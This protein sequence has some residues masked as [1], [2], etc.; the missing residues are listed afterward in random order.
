[1]GS[2]WLFEYQSRDHH[3]ASCVRRPSLGRF[4]TGAALM[5]GLVMAGC[6]ADAPA[7]APLPPGRSVNTLKINGEERSYILR[8]PPKYD[9]KTKVPLVI[10]MNGA[11]DSAKYAEEAYHFAEKGDASN[12]ALVLPEALGEGHAWNG[13]GNG[14][15]EKADVAFL[16]NLLESLPKQYAIDTHHMYVSGHS[17]GAIMAY[18]IAA[19]RPDLVAAVGVVA[20]AVDKDFPTPKSPVPVI[21]FHGRQ[22]PIF[23]YGDPLPAG[24]EHP[25]FNVVAGEVAYWCKVNGCDTK[26]TKTDRPVPTVQRDLFEGPKKAEVVLYS[27]DR[28]NH[29]WPGGKEMPGKTM[30]PV[31]DISATDL[32]WDF[33]K[34]HARE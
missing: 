28:G 7:T 32:M 17:M 3:G 1:M 4:L 16:T 11:S 9:G 5:A 26:P 8:L 13:L 15:S 21:M 34:G 27:L 25:D 33:F 18:R 29:M 6:G 22:D 31:Q 14:E 19:E 12:F 2:Y 24:L 10:L 23:P 20:G 30:I